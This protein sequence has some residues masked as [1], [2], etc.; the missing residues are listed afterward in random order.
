MAK[1]KQC[2]KEYSILTAE[3]GAG[4]CRECSQAQQTTQE[5]AY[6]KRLEDEART[7][8]EKGL[9]LQELIAI[10]KKQLYWLRLMGLITLCAWLSLLLGVLFRQR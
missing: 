3:L 4:I 2:G 10:N 7:K 1:C 9:S 8:A 5:Q 6:T